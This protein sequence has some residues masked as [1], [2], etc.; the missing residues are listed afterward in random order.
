MRA[1]VPDGSHWT[2]K[3]DFAKMK[4][5]EITAFITKASQQ[6]ED[7]TFKTYW[8]D[9]KAQGLLRG[10]YHYLDWRIDVTQQANL[11]CSL[12]AGDAGELP[13][14]LD[15]EMNPAVYS[16]KA[17]PELTIEEGGPRPFSLIK[18]FKGEDYKE[19]LPKSPTTFS[20]SN[21]DIVSRVLT[22]LNIVE[23][24]T[25]VIPMI[26]SG[27]YYWNDFMTSDVSWLKYPFWLAWYNSES[28]I[29]VPQPWTQWT[30]WQYTD[31]EYGPTYGV[32]GLGL[33]MSYYNGTNEELAEWAKP[34]PTPPAPPPVH[35]SHACDICGFVHDWPNSGT[36]YITVGGNPNVRA[37]PGG[38][39]LG[40][41]MEGTTITVDEIVPLAVHFIPRPNFPNG[42]WIHINYVKKL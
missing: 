9:A 22:F 16:M 23:S 18:P 21:S 24:K 19:K 42:G 25:G 27:Y 4:A 33:D 20:L 29:R 14:I 10:A 40:Y 31:K 12:L 1:K 5:Q 2:G 26:Y 38:T 37:T 30:L 34:I 17:S 8:R 32:E 15:L 36:L 11:F 13:P 35:T 7:D 3:I 6:I 28:V 39:I 41:L